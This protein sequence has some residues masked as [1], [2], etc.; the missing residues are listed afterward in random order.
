MEI[1]VENLFVDIGAKGGKHLMHF[2][3]FEW[4]GINLFLLVGLPV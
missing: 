2:A 1:S 4:V 3:V